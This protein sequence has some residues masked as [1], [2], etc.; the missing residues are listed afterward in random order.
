MRQ[1]N[2]VE[3]L[4]A[5]FG[6]AGVPLEVS[7]EPLA[8]TVQVTTEQRA[9]LDRGEPVVLSDVMPSEPPKLHPDY[10]HFAAGASLEE[11]AQGMREMAEGYQR[12]DFRREAA[13]WRD[14]A[15]TVESRVALERHGGRRRPTLYT[16]GLRRVPHGGRRRPGAPVSRRASGAQSRGSTRGDPDLADSE[17]PAAPE[18]PGDGFALGRIDRWPLLWRA[19]SARCRWY[20]WREGIAR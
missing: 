17:P 8:A 1:R 19:R 14:R 20:E 15:R 12:G 7:A 6:A 5:E 16:P 9:A 10:P 2:R 13:R 11:I 18:K 3:R 4:I